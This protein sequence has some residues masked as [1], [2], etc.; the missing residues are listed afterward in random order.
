MNIDFL[1]DRFKKESDKIAIIYN[2]KKYPYSWLIEKINEC[3]NNFISLGLNN[4]VVSL[5][6]DYDP[7]SIAS[8]FA[9]LEIDSIIVPFNKNIKK[10]NRLEYERIAEVEKAITFDGTD[11][12]VSS[13][14]VKAS[15]NLILQLKRER[16]PGLILFSSG[17][18]GDSKAIVHDFDS[19]IK[20]FRHEKKPSKPIIPFLMFDHIGGINTLFYTLSNTG[21]IVTIDN[22]S[23]EEICAAVEKYKV[24][25][26]PVSPTFL[27]LLI[28]SEA[29]KKF[30]LSSLEVISYGTEVMSESILKKI[31]N[32]FPD[33]KI[34]QTYGLSETGILNSRSEA[35]N[36]TWVKLGGEN[37]ELRVKN[38]MLEIKTPSAMMGYIN[39]SSPFTEDGWIKTND[40]VEQKGDYYRIIGRNSDIINVGG[41]KVYPSEVENILL[42]MNNVEDVSI[43]GEKNIIL[44]QIVKAKVK[45]KDNMS[46]RDFS[47]K[48]KIF[49]RDKLAGYKIPQKVEIIKDEELYSERFKKKRM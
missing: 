11:I 32:I 38:N 25:I 17:S 35:N 1:Y 7:Y 27:N 13:K 26:L 37:I 36:S 12:V 30:D 23:V 14:D 10:H 21:C 22:H 16:H 40:L 44:G 18:T 15:H 34:L 48:M 45:L 20:K 33:I 5:I 6:G 24:Q 8:F 39:A 4:K 43:V 46:L 31:H 41:E 19:L 29:Y 49:C 2:N 42:D 47:I 9:L 28:I 3:Q